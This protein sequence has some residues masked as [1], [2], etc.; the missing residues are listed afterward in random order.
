MNCHASACAFD[1][2]GPRLGSLLLCAAIAAASLDIAL[3]ADA[4]APF[5]C[6]QGVC[7]FNVAAYELRASPCKDRPVLVAYS[8][9]GG[10]TLIQC[11]APS[12]SARN[13]SYLFDRRSPERAI[14]ELVGTR[15]IK[16][17]LLAEAANGG[18]PDRFGAVPLCVKPEPASAAIGEILLVLKTLAQ[19]AG[20]ADCYRLLRVRTDRGRLEIRAD[21][22]AA[23]AASTTA[24]AKWRALV[25][26]LLPH[27]R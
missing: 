10:A 12:D 13:L 6:F 18:V 26:R 19:D 2:Q 17:D 22:G 1:G 20:G 7:G 5:D 4:V 27:I 24:R 23:P 9:P 15:F 14:F 11:S 21:K 8:Q 3:A 25:G 16:S